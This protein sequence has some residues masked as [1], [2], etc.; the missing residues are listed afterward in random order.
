MRPDGQSQCVPFA[1]A[2]LVKSAEIPD[3][4]RARIVA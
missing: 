1:Q 4:L 3:D 2:R